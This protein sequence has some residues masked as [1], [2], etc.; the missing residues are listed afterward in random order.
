MQVSSR[1]LGDV[2]NSV[3]AENENSLISLVPVPDGK[4]ERKA[5]SSGAST[6]VLGAYK[7]SLL[8]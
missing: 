5:A 1:N 8:Y 4:P 3:K 6:F 7:R 2:K